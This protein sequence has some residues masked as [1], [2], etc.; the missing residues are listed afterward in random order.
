ME[1]GQQEVQPRIPLGRTWS[2]LTEYISQRNRLQR[3]YVNDQRLESHLEVQ[4]PGG[5]NKKDKGESS[6]YPSYR[7]NADPDRTYSDS[8][9]LT[10]TRPNQ[11]SS[12]LTPFRNQKISGQE[13]PFFT[14][15][16][17]SQEKTRI[18]W[19]TQAL[20][21]QK[22]E[23]VRPTDPEAFE[24]GERSTQEPEI[25]VHNSRLSSLIHKNINPHSD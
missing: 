9:R 17:S 22:K 24:L 11:L 5:E 10:R 25:V 20:F 6:H 13:S 18:Q 7:R 16:G 4:T 21:Q 19:K 2:K 1:H 12:G 8:F 3:P 15:L 14:I 23:R